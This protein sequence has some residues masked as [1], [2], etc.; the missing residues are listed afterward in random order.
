M[1]YPLRRTGP[2]GSKQFARI[3]WDDALDEIT[4]KW[5][6]I[7]D[8]HGPQ[9]I[10]PYSYLGHQGLVHG[11]NGGDSF[12]NRMGATVTERTFCGEGAATAWLLTH[13]PSGGMD[14]ESFV[15]SKFI[16]IWA[17]NSV[18]TNLH[19]WHIVKDAQKKGAKVVVIDAYASKTAKEADW[20]IAPK[21]GPTARWRWQ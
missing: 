21:P 6:A 7:I 20:H 15:H 14:P 19:H 18:S 9:A 1:L 4:T 8:E 17:C 16:I 5:K 3:S 11:L 10:V 2:K 12:F 13:G